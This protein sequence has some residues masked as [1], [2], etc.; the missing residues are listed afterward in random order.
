M[1]HCPSVPTGARQDSESSVDP[2]SSLPRRVHLLGAGGAG[3]SG[4]ARLLLS[5]GHELSGFD[6]EAGPFTRVLELAGVSIAL[7][8]SRADC[9]PEGVGLVVRSAAVSAQDPQ[10]LAAGE[11]GLEVLKYAE[12]LGRLAPRGLTLSV[13]G[14]HGK[15]TTTW[16]LQHALQGIYGGLKLEEKLRPGALVGGLHQDLGT[17]ALPGG[18]E[19]FF[20]LEACEYDRSFLQLYSAGAAVTNIEA[21]HLDCYGSLENIE[22]AFARFLSQV[23]SEGLVVLG[24]DVPEHLDLAT[25]ATVWRIGRELQVRL[26]GEERGYF[27]MH[28]QGPGWRTPEFRL[29]VPGPFNVQNAAVALGLA[30]GSTLQRSPELDPAAVAA[31]AAMGLAAFPGVSRRFE[32]WGYVEDVQLVHDYAHHPTEVAATCEA[33]RRVF[34]RRPVFV[35]FQPHQHSRTA[36]LLP[37]FIEALRCTDGV[38]V[39]DVYGARAHI[40]RHSAGAPELVSGLMRA[41]IKAC[42]GGPP[43]EAA[44]VFA[45]VLPRRCA[46]LIMG[47]GDI[48]GIQITLRDELALRC[49]S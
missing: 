27:S 5:R 32:S 30:V 3:L 14:T 38:V 41:G 26:M 40:D 7:G 21:D 31:A 19:G 15:T 11:R 43:A 23:D 45:Q 16:M 49:S 22:K 4:A 17:N 29:Q 37:E 6:R 42:L 10:V 25:D 35:L 24:S 9:L 2:R 33:A 12:L 36:R 34:P 18:D 13:A 1:H 44:R 8:E 48:D 47:A 46:A 28:V 20:A 39:A